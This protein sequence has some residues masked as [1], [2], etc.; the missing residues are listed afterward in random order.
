M[1]SQ[2]I[3][4]VLPP[5]ELSYEDALAE[6]EQIVAALESDSQTLEISIKLF[7][8]GQALAQHC[9]AL[10]EKAEQKVRQL[11][12]ENLLPFAPGDEE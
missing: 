7:E 8:R 6:L 10:L 2:T 3:P 9:S 1:T 4:G 12:G 11:V 5:E